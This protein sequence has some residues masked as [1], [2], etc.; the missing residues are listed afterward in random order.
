MV[1]LQNLKKKKLS[2]LPFSAIRIL[3]FILLTVTSYGQQREDTKTYYNWFDVQTG[4]QN[5]KVY[6]GTAYVEKY[7]TINEKHKFFSS[8]EFL[9]GSLSFEGQPF[10]SLEL[11]YDLYEDQLLLNSKG[12]IGTVLRLNT[13]QV[14]SFSIASHKFINLK[15]YNKNGLE[16]SGFYEILLET[17]S[18]ILLKKNKKSSLKKIKGKRIYYE[19]KNDNQNLLFYENVYY[20]LNKK[21]DL[22]RLFPKFKKIINS[23][24]NTSRNTSDTDSFMKALLRKIEEELLKQKIE[25][26]K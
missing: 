19:F 13:D 1:V 2:S 23:Y 4:V 16:V 10:Y 22:L 3:A 21:R 25:Q 20:E 17:R 24:Y 15:Q 12:A 26:A 14:N 5:K 18:F 8:Y 9:P 11:K 7:R 6:N